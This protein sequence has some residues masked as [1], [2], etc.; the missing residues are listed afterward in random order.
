MKYIDAEKLIA[1]IKGKIAEIEK[2]PAPVD[3]ETILLQAC[4]TNSF[5]EVLSS[6]NRL[7][8]DSLQQEQPEVDLEEAAEEALKKAY[9]GDAY[10]YVGRPSRRLFKEGFKDGYMCKIMSKGLGNGPWNKG[11]QPSGIQLA[12]GVDTETIKTMLLTWE[13]MKLVIAAEGSIYDEHHGNS[14]EVFEAYPTEE[15]FYGEVLRRYNE[16]KK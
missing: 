9:P 8:K 1:E 6:I 2:E 13:D 11:Y 16:L 7:K 10:Y 5:R 15:A 12:N 4:K 3:R 14:S